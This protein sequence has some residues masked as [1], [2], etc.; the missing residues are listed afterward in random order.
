MNSVKKGKPFIIPELESAPLPRTRPWTDDEAAIVEKY[1]GKRDARSIA[2]YL[3]EKY[4]PGRST[5]AIRN[6]A[7]RMEGE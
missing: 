1:F 5:D 6:K 3:K 4:P 2:I 7:Y